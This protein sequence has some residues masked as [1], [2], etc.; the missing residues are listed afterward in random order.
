MVRTGI[1]GTRAGAPLAVL[2]VV[3]IGCG[4][5]SRT[6]PP[7]PSL[8]TVEPFVARRILA[9]TEAVRAE[10]GS[11]NLW[12]Q[13]GEVYDLH[14]LTAE[15]VF[16]YEQAGRL[17]P[18]EWRW[19]YY[20][21]IL[22]RT[23]DQGTALTRFERAA[24]LAPDYASI[25]FYIG[26]G[27]YQA[28]ELDAAERHFS[29]ALEL[30]PGMVNALLGLGRVSMARGEPERALSY[31]EHAARLAPDE[32]A[33]HV[34]LAQVHR[35]SGE[36]QRADEEQRRAAASPRR[37]QVG[38]MA[39]LVD[40]VREELVLRQG[41][42]LEWLRQK[43]R[44]LLDEQ[45]GEEALQTWEEVIEVDPGSTGALVESARVLIE[46]G[47]L[48]EARERVGR[49]LQ[50]EP[51]HGEAN[52]V[53][54]D[55]LAAAGDRRAAI[56]AYR[57]AV[58]LEPGLHEARTRLA[59]LL[60]ETGRVEEG[61]R[62]LRITVRER[63]DNA[64]VRFNLARALSFSDRPGEAV[65]ASRE[66]L[67]LD[68]DHR[69][70]RVLLRDLGRVLWRRQRFEESIEAFRLAAD[71]PTEQAV[72]SRE[73]AWALATCPEA[74]LRDGEAALTIARRLCDGADCRNPQFLD[75]LAA[76]QAETGDFSGAVE[77]VKKSIVLAERS[78]EGQ[79]QPDRRARIE[80]LLRQLR[81]RQEL[82]ESGRPYRD[83]VRL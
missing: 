11:A 15:A 16:C 67:A 64:D 8:D 34:H 29:R 72:L 32:A 66:A 14:D 2:L 77:S 76:A 47:R 50:L 26:Y 13:L 10:P 45:R 9:A 49:A 82:Y 19:P 63:P 80:T 39:A 68:P 51:E 83:G 5:G 46:L 81:S 27:R 48:D 73:L 37:P 40:P 20:V 62:M 59:R 75:T 28:E 17:D 58:D 3:A 53:R 43:T 54:G 30:D 23:S 35:A 52:A 25:H 7:N 21:G 70:T 44:R 41:V 57:D 24:E 65:E 33:V 71:G 22:L 4:G 36:P 6:E 55:L 1:G 61:L 78:L 12:G 60:L 74:R 31:F 79:Q 42:S 56:A 18:T 38:G 69:E